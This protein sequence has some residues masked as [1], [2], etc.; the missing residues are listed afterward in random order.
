MHHWGVTQWLVNKWRKVAIGKSAAL[1]PALVAMHATARDPV[2]RAKI[3]RKG[4]PRPAY[5][6]AAMRKRQLGK[7]L[8]KATRA[9]MSEAHK[10]R[11][12]QP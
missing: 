8:P 3:A 2:R 7:R 11:G 12:T 6:V 10:R 5:V 4:K 9:K 1:V